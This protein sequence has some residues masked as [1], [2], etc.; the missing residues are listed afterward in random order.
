MFQ[1][2]YEQRTFEGDS[3]S[4]TGDLL[5]SRDGLPSSR[6]RP[7]WR[8]RIRR[9]P[10]L[11]IAICI[12]VVAAVL[13]F[14]LG[15]GLGLSLGKKHK[16][17][18]PEVVDL[19][20]SKYQGQAMN[21]GISQWLGIRYAAPPV[22]ELR[23]AAPQPPP[24]NNIIQQANQ[25]CL[26]ADIVCN[27][28]TNIHMKHGPVCLNTR[29]NVATGDTIQDGFSEDCLFLDVYAP[30]NATSDSSLPVYVYIQGGGF[31]TNSNP[32]MNGGVLVAASGMNIVVVT[33][34]YRVGPYGFLA[35][36]EVQ[37]NGSLNNGLKD[38]RQALQ[39]IQN[40]I[41][42]VRSCAN[43]KFDRADGL[44]VWRRSRT[45]NNGRLQR[46]RSIR[47]PTTDSIRRQR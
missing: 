26:K 29:E 19:G 6:P 34:G 30:T 18:P 43:L 15:L 1:G 17:T 3:A 9:R 21:G 36:S 13:A 47:H 11:T 23:F 14:A 16:S 33:L 7:T 20:Y 5:K 44:L 10:K 45:C 35:S 40:Y 39:W 25:V 32:N 28:L 8:Q 2:K 31:N 27:P 37:A 4:S 46:R 41:S 24:K 22:G 38:Q 42:M 12:A